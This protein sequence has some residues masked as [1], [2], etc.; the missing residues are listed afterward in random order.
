MRVLVTGASGYIGSAVARELHDAGHLV[1]GLARSTASADALT[2]AGYE[3]LRGSLDDLDVL[4]RGAKEAD[5]VVNLAF[6]NEGLRTDFMA[7]VRQDQAAVEVMLDALEGTNK[8][9]V[10]TSGTLMLS[11]L[12]RR[13]TE[14]DVLDSSLPRVG[15]ENLV[16]ES[17]QRAIR[18][19]TI[20][21][22]PSV[23]G[24]GDLHGFVPGLIAIA[25][26]KGV[27]GYVGDGANRWPGVHRL[28]AA[29]LYR[30]AVENAPAGTR[31]HGVDD[32]GVA[33]K[34]IA[35]AIGRQLD[36]PVVSISPE[37]APNHFGYL[38][39]F[40]G[41]DNPTSNAITRERLQWEP[42]HPRLLEDINEGF[43]FTTP[44]P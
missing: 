38:A 30:L 32:E 20:R 7:S 21:L 37:D 1:V 44:V 12:G 19:S 3:V 29:R 43:Y 26:E 33:F 10:N 39:M 13:G 27:S 9:F 41:W 2:S 17:A 31:L 22:A 4:A 28:D 6:D 25:R 5:A 11:F 15:T 42:T 18:S 24:P 8:P 35:E 14:D 34:Q 40:V 23:H 36:V 16:I